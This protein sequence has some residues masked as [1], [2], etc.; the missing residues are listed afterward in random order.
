MGQ[1]YLTG[2]GVAKTHIN[3]AISAKAKVLDAMLGEWRVACTL[4]RAQ[5]PTP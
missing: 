5:T 3:N 4:T 2:E 1:L